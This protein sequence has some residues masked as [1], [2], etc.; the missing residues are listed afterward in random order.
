MK[1]APMD[2]AVVLSAASDGG[3]LADIAYLSME[4]LQQRW[5]GMSRCEVSRRCKNAGVRFIRFGLS[6]NR[7]SPRAYLLADVQTH[8]QMHGLMRR[9]RT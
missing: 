9:K 3:Q 1:S 5:G 8:E 2:D 6:A 4:A 7:F